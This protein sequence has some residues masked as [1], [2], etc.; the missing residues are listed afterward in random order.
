[1]PEVLK[2]SPKKPDPAL[3]MNAVGLLRRGGVIAYPTETFYGL[4]VD[5]H[6]EKAIEK[7]FRIKGRNFRN[8][9]S[10]IMGNKKD[11]V[12]LVEDIPEY[13]QILMQNFWPG[14]LTIVF[15]ASP[16]ISPLLTAGTGKIGIRVSS[17]PIATALAK[18]LSHPITA[19]SANLS[20]ARECTSAN[21]VIQSIGDQIDVVID[22][23]P[24]PGIAGSTILDVTTFPATILR[25][26]IIPA[27]LLHTFYKHY[28]QI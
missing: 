1:M 18:A 9:V 22:S 6:N 7:I 5:G 25:E 20:G 11:L 15:K 8:P 14:A 16:N 10:I 2:I 26:G 13:S 28:M 24:T 17:H 27:S 23:G 12:H 21:E 19:T 3:I 4:G